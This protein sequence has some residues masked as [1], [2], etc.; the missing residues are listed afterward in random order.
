MNVESRLGEG[1]VWLRQARVTVQTGHNFWSH[2]WIAIKIL[3]EYPKA[4]FHI[5]DTKSILGEEEFG[6]RQA[7]VTIRNRNIFWS[8]CWILI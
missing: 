3:K 8:E 5:V 6:S 1:E 7:R 2:R 4:L